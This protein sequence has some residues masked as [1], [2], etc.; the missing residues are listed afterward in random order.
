MC[1]VS[2]LRL[3]D[4]IAQEEDKTEVGKGEALPELTIGVR[5]AAGNKCER[6][7]V[8]DPSVGVDA[9]HPTLCTR[10]VDVVRSL[11]D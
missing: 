8:I 2:S 1:I 3:V 6:C 4:T 9:E 10:C 7:W 11:T 5:P